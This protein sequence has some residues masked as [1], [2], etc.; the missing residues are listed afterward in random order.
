MY[1][2]P[3]WNLRY[4]K[5]YSLWTQ[6]LLLCASAVSRCSTLKSNEIIHTFFQL[7]LAPK[8]RCIAS[9][10]C[11]VPLVV[12]SIHLFMCRHFRAGNIA[13]E[14]IS[15]A[16]WKM[17]AK[18]AVMKCLLLCCMLTTNQNVFQILNISPSTFNV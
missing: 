2:I 6:D 16:T 10:T 4:I 8:A 7:V 17:Q 12:L 1:K 3:K 5:S 13:A 14:C 11:R 15:M 18:L 9:V